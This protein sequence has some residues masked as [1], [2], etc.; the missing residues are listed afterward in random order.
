MQF[1]ANSKLGNTIIP[2]APHE[3]SS[4]GK[5][6][7]DMLKRQDLIVVN[8]TEKCSGV[9]T[10]IKNTIRGLEESAIDYFVV[11]RLLF[12]KVSKMTIDEDRNHVLTRF[13]KYKTKTSTVESDHNLLFLELH[14]KWNQK[15]KID[16]K[17]VYNLR[18]K[19]C[20]K[21]FTENT[22]NNKTFIEVLQNSDIV[23]GGAK[24]I[25][26][27]KHIIT[28]S[29]KKIRIGNGKE[30]PSNELVELF[31]EREKLKQ[32]INKLEKNNR[33]NNCYSKTKVVSELTTHMKPSHDRICDGGEN[34][35]RKRILKQ[36]L[37]SVTEKIADCQAEKNYKL[38]RE[39]VENLIDDTDN[40]NSLKMWELKKRLGA[41]KKDVPVAKKDSNGQ[42]VTN[43]L[44]LKE[45][46]KNTYRKRMEHREMKSELIKMYELKM[47]LFELRFKVSQE[48]KCG[49]WSP[50]NLLK[51]LK[52]LKKKKSADSEGLIYELFRPEN[53]GE[54]LFFS[55]L[56]LCNKMKSEMAVPRFLINTN[57]TSI[58]KNKGNKDDLEN[59]R[60]IFGVTKVRSIVEKLIYE[61]V[62]DKIDTAMSD[63]NVGARRKR[64][65][66][67]N[68]FA[69]YSTIND[70][71]RSRKDI[72]IQFYDLAKCFDSMWAEETMNDLYDVGVKDEK[73]AFISLMN[74]NC[75][76]RVK[77]PV[78]DTEQFELSRI[79]MQGTVPAP[80]KCAV[81]IDTL[82]R[83]C[84]TYNTGCYICKSA[85]NIPPLYIYQ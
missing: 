44:Q 85:C 82:G 32:T 65:I 16:R 56:M 27:L 57:I 52:S 64:N 69:L 79:E 51:V 26:E 62:Y 61:E 59:D 18:N 81:Q 72:D 45:L 58:Y 39:H 42:L 2:G 43:S 22:S 37:E 46:Y 75:K 33:C 38:I 21:N 8:S 67:D 30:K 14:I 53:I 70:A 77:T 34:C 5:I 63:S 80:I 19:D 12:E 35:Q 49:D 66:R 71:I 23:S 24:W 6:L 36:K 3:I 17:E 55:L 1:D 60:G 9:I 83:Y 40:L 29:F 25:K 7:F 84:Y 28:K 13:Y 41:K 10:R 74:E 48:R 73:F 68:L 31:G 20:L 50:N 47:N 11:C 54:D 76:V 4:N 78:G 15:I